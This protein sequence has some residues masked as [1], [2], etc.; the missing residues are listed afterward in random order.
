M[1][2]RGAASRSL[3]AAV[4]GRTSSSSAASR[5]RA[6]APLPAA[7]R[8]RVPAFAT[9]RPLAAM[10]GSPAAVVARLTGHT[11][12]T[13]RACCELSQGTLFCRTCQDR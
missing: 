2:W 5:L 10:A 6:A 11:A 8:R 1:A 4:R 7:P 3:L 9:A 13:V 12:A